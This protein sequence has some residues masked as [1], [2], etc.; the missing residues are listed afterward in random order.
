M[1]VDQITPEVLDWTDQGQ[2]EA[3][4]RNLVRTEVLRVGKEYRDTLAAAENLETRC[5]M[6]AMRLYGLGMTQMELEHLF[7]VGRERM[8]K[9][10]ASIK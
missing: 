7:G 5:K 2:E 10:L 3:R 6:R 8:N 9:W 4:I 1:T